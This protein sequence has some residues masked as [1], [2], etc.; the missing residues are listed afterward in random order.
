MGTLT[1]S[2]VLKR[3]ISGDVV[4]NA[5]ITFDAIATG[6]V[7]LKGVS[8]ACKTASDGSYSVDLEYGDY[9]IQ[10]SWSGQTLQ[11]G[12]VHIDDT[13]PVGSLNDLLL[14]EVMESQLT[15][16]IV[17]EFRQLEQ[18]M[19]EDLS[20]MDA[21]NNQAADSADS[22][23]ASAAAAK[24]SET[25]SASSEAAAAASAA[26]AKT[27]ETNSASSEA[28]AAASAAAAKTSETNS[29]SSE[30]AAAASAA[31]AK[32]SETNSASSEV[33]AAAS[34]AAAKTSETNSASSEEHAANSETN[35]KN[36]RDAAE[37]YANEAKDAASK[38][39]SPLTDQGAW[40]IKAGYPRTPD[41]ASIWQ[42]TDGGVDPVNSDI[43]WDAGDMMVYLAASKTWC[44]LLGQQTVAGEP[45]PLK[46][47]SDIILNVGS[48]LQFVT[49]GTSAVDVARL[50][51][52]NN[53]IVGD[54]KLP[55]VAL[56][57]SDP[58][59]LFVL[60]PDGNGGYTKSRIYTEQ[61]PPPEKEPPVTSVNG[62]I[63]DVYFPILDNTVT[64]SNHDSTDGHLLKIGDFNIGRVYAPFVSGFDF[65]T[66]QFAAGET[67]FVQ[68]N[69]ALN[70]PS[71]LSEITSGGAYISVI[72]IRDTNNDALIQ[73]SDYSSY[74]SFNL[75][76]TSVDPTSP[77]WGGFKLSDQYLSNTGG[78]VNGSVTVMGD[79]SLNQRFKRESQSSL[80]TTFLQDGII[81]SITTPLWYKIATVQMPQ[82]CTAVIKIYGGNGYNGLTSNNDIV[83]ILLRTGNGASA[84]NTSG[85]MGLTLYKTGGEG[86]GAV[87]SIAAVETSDGVY[88]I[89]GVVNA[90]TS[91]GFAEFLCSHY[92]ST[93]T[94]PME[95]YGDGSTPPESY[96][97][98]SIINY[99]WNGTPIQANLNGGL[100]APY[101]IIN[102][103]DGTCSLAVGDNDTGFG[104]GGDGILEVF[105]NN[106]LVETINVDGVHC[107]GDFSVGASGGKNFT[108]RCDRNNMSSSNITFNMW[109]VSD[110]PTV[111]E[112]DD[113][114]GWQFYSQ[115][116]SNGNVE[117]SVDGS[118]F[119][120]TGRVYSPG[121]PPPASPS[122]TASLG[123][124]GWF[125]DQSTGMI[126]QWGYT[127][128]SRGDV[129][130]PIAF[131][132][133]CFVVL[134]TTKTTADEDT[135]LVDGNTY[136]WN[137]A[138]DTW[139]IAIGY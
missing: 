104:S 54:D 138:S 75:W 94:F 31:A 96:Q 2:G 27:S 92:C 59:N 76:R 60:V 67:L 53:L 47:D 37:E 41:V 14:Q 77:V 40:A 5:R 110:R 120:N 136:F 108:M 12:S 131:P 121:N 90:Y 29:A 21:L 9:A 61:F 23:A 38:V 30:A 18:Q 118:I 57:A 84:V 109:G 32:T 52:D 44:R 125:K 45:V 116:L 97:S 15:P 65:N 87:T 102:R 115:R 98:V 28:A 101:A 1:L 139:W 51:T 134:T 91:G 100:S 68:L 89:Y 114:S 123:S 127:T 137:G 16:E 107:F 39:T 128:Q 79:I 4:P 58:T 113:D 69:S 35:A 70:V 19:Q 8:S 20:Q 24:T 13:T 50:D 105:A 135:A 111:M 126:I 25:N 130:F 36:A 3:P 7:V 129:Y 133:S 71:L 11:Y 86:E 72:A 34:A 48:G 85:R 42:I 122:G 49:S 99:I 80:T 106:S 83:T 26:A 117:F 64:T 132:N 78:T 119:D 112:C 6:N 66:Y 10:V 62:E 82:P 63:G 88:D 81:P 124:N 73:V 56:K 103:M 43:I 55:G 93:A 95:I 22:A 17:L 46:L 74:I 33:A